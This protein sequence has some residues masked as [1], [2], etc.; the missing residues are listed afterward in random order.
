M[1]ANF[2]LG[3]RDNA[4]NLAGY[5]ANKDALD[6]PRIEALQELGEWARPHGRDKIMGLWRPLAPRDGA[7][8][9][10]ALRPVLAEILH[11]A[12]NAVRIAC[13]EA[14]GRLEIAA[15]APL[16]AELVA[17]TKAN[18]SVRVEALKALAIVKGPKLADAVQLAVK[19][20]SEALRKEGRR[21]LAEMNPGDAIDVLE[22]VLHNGTMGEKQSA[23]ANIATIPGIAAD[24]LVSGW[25]DQLLSGHVAPELKL[26]LLEA[27]AKRTNAEITAKL[28]KY[29]ASL[30]AKDPLAPYR[31]ALAGGNAAEGRKIFFERAEASCLRCHR[32][33]GE[34]GDVGP[35]QDGIGT[36]QTREYMLESIVLPNAKIAPG[37][38]TVIVTT[39][40]GGSVAGI[41]KSETDQ[42]LV[43][44]SPEDGL[45]KVKKAD[46]AK[47]ERGQSGMPEGL[48]QVLSKRDLR[49]LIEFLSSLK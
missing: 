47:R 10:A 19:D 45:I 42:E 14:V 26:E 23:L 13:I 44:N 2:R 4:V 32:V 43:L 1:N 25:L 9:A 3:G 33:H 7:P 27:A 6:I 28:A 5:A 48:G 49:D 46:I 24:L 16:L 34:G 17:D 21:L 41:L 22:G 35:S 15:A 20:S 30:D 40:T 29:E 37:F 36:R 8:A 12:P 39:K 18:G 38:E 31:V 11:N